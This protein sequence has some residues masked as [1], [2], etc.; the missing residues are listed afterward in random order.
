MSLRHLSNQTDMR[1]HFLVEHPIDEVYFC[2]NCTDVCTSSEKMKNHCCQNKI[3]GGVALLFKGKPWSPLQC[4]FC[5]SSSEALYQTLLSYEN[6]CL[7]AHAGQCLICSEAFRYMGNKRN[8]F[9]SSHSEVGPY[10]CSKCCMKPSRISTP[11]MGI[12]L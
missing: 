12:A 4:P 7:N 6:H 11:S 5:P 8:H 1:I 3:Q 10:F 9:R 2:N